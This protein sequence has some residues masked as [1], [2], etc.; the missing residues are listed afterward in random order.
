MKYG[1]KYNIIASPSPKPAKSQK[2]YHSF[3]SLVLHY[4][5]PK[6]ILTQ[7]LGDT[8]LWLIRFWTWH[9]NVMVGI[10]III[11]KAIRKVS[12]TPDGKYDIVSTFG[13]QKRL[14]NFVIILV[15]HQKNF[16]CIKITLKAKS[17][18]LLVE[19]VFLTIVP[20]TNHQ[21]TPVN[22]QTI[23]SFYSTS[24]ALNQT[25]VKK[26]WIYLW[27]NSKTSYVAV[28]LLP[29]FIN[30]YSTHSILELEDL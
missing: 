30:I 4:Q 14:L 12:I 11:A 1:Q 8:F 2:Y 26:K 17:R 10:K 28:K 21:I 24:Q 29:I 19:K 9:S 3:C 6:L 22:Y 13:Q 25:R 7:E 23:S 15:T 5:I 27:S 18:I 20:K 16:N